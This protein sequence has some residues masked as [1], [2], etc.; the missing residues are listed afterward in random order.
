MVNE[1]SKFVVTGNRPIMSNFV[2]SALKYRPQHFEDVVGQSEVTQTLENAIKN[3]KL[4]QSYLFCGPRGVGKT[5]CARI[6]AK[7][8][9]NQG[10]IDEDYDYSFNIFE[11]DAASNSSVDDIRLL[12]DQVRVPPAKGLF[13]V[14]IIDE[15]HMLSKNAFNAFLKTLEEPPPFCKFILA[16]TEKQKVLPTIISRCQVFDFKRI[17]DQ[18]MVNHLAKICEKEGIKY[19]EGSLEIIAQ[20]ADGA[21]RDAL[22]I[23]DRQVS[24]TN[25]NLLR[26][27]VLENLNILDSA[28]YFQLTDAIL[29]SDHSSVL[30][31]VEDILQK[32]F[33]EN[34]LIV[35]LAEHFRNLLVSKDSNT[36]GLINNQVEKDQYLNQGAAAN[37]GFLLTALDL[38]AKTAG[39]LRTNKNQRLTL[40][41]GLLKICHIGQ[42]V[43]V[44][45]TTQVK[46]NPDSITSAANP[47]PADEKEKEIP[48][49]PATEKKQSP[50]PTEETTPTPVNTTTPAAEQPGEKSENETNLAVNNLNSLEDF[51]KS[52]QPQNTTEPEK[53]EEEDETLADNPNAPD[54]A[55]LHVLWNEIATD[56]IQN[57]AQGLG[58]S[59]QSARLTILNNNT[60]KVE[61]ANGVQLNFMDEARITIME[62]LK[63]GLNLFR[64]SLNLELNKS[65]SPT[66]EKRP[67]TTKE[68]YDEM[69]KKNPNLQTLKNQLGLDLEL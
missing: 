65:L 44:S 22:S 61:V 2:V 32:G 49:P 66:E 48:T 40:E 17:T 55:K 67:Y 63:T 20:K 26:A 57:G 64:L 4:A 52:I 51:A 41:L 16:T 31:L 12:V 9:N 6:F 59:M 47:S 33:Q 62:K 5:T 60:I 42:S 23:F 46:K 21:L 11:L 18:D 34:D 45:N 10:V 69:V 28:Y 37:T 38:A 1:F 27:A 15:V 35:G 7:V 58:T 13:K 30:L 54:E 3:D 53:K 50:P 25:A 56:A 19:E 36:V 68:K 39:A 43:T 14:Y 29:Q 8:I 24:F